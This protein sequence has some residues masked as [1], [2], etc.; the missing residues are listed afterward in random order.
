MSR[1][2][3]GVI[4]SDAG[5][6]SHIFPR[7]SIALATL[8]TALFACVLVH[9]VSTRGYVWLLQSDA[10]HFFGVA[11]D[12]FGSGTTL[13]PA[14]GVGTAY[15]YGRIAYPLMAWLLAADRPRGWYIRCQLSI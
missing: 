15:R 13:S 5:P 14:P 9:A 12:P 4:P 2:A 3:I 6:R 1:L 11:L 10:Q 8:V 7:S